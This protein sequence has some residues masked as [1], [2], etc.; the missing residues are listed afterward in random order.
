VASPTVIVSDPLVSEPARNA[1]SNRETASRVFYGSIISEKLGEIEQ[2]EI[3]PPDS[4]DRAW[5]RA[6]LPHK[7]ERL[8]RER[9]KANEEAKRLQGQVERLDQLLEHQRQAM[10]NQKRQLEKLRAPDAVRACRLTQIV[11]EIKSAARKKGQKLRQTQIAIGVDKWLETRSFELKNVCPHGWQKGIEIEKFP[12]LFSECIKH[13][14]LRGKAKTL[15]T[16]A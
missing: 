6:L 8:E 11:F 15:I 14:T 7:M 10:D 12:R 2:Q 3:T 13:P 5:R 9:E 16:R 4:Q 1:E